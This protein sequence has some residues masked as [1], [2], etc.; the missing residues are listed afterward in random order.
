M[1]TIT[2]AIIAGVCGLVGAVIGAL[3]TLYKARAER[4]KFYAEAEKAKANGARSIVEAAQMLVNE[5]QERIVRVEEF[6]ASEI[7]RLNKTVADLEHEIGDMKRYVNKLWE[8]AKALYSQVE[9]LGARPIYIPTKPPWGNG[10][11]M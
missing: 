5:Y 1:E 6:S 8:G 11:T 10:R 2:T 7:E 3:V 4:S 9:Q